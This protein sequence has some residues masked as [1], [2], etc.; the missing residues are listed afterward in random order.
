MRSIPTVVLLVIQV[1]K[2]PPSN[3]VRSASLVV[4][5]LLCGSKQVDFL[6][7]GQGDDNYN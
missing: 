3:R 4:L 2:S 1:P 7:F 6:C 5:F